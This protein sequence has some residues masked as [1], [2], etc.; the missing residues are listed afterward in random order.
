MAATPNSSAL[1]TFLGRG[2]NVHMP[3]EARKALGLGKGDK[4]LVWVEGEQIVLE[5]APDKPRTR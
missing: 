2:G 3:R 4:L 1:A 5:R